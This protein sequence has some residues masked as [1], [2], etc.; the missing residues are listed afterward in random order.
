MSENKKIR[1]LFYVTPKFKWKYL[2]NWAITIW[3]WC[4]YSHVELWVPDEDSGFT[5]LP[6]SCFVGYR[7]TC[8]SS[9]MRGSDNGTR[10]ADASLV[11]KHPENWEYIEIAV[12]DEQYATL[13][14]NMNWEVAHNKGYAMRDILKFIS[15]IHFPDNNRFICSEF[16]YEMLGNIGVLKDCGIISPKKLYKKLIAVGYK[17]E[18]LV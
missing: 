14:L 3:T 18:K 9:T 5:N 8:Y 7:G 12:T 6:S 2:V 11:L 16:C 17:V 15:P 1:C 10:K 13:M 4:R